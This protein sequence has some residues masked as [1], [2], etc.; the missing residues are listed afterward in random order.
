MH[1]NLAP[2]VTLCLL[3][4]SLSFAEVNLRRVLDDAKVRN[5]LQDKANEKESQS[6]LEKLRDVFKAFDTY[7]RDLSKL[8]KVGAERSYDD[9][10]KKTVAA[11][12]YDP[13]R[14]M[15]FSSSDEFYLASNKF[16]KD[17]RAKFEKERAQV[18]ERLLS[19]PAILKI[20]TRARALG[21]EK[22]L[23]VDAV[24]RDIEGLAKNGNE[25]MFRTIIKD[26]NSLLDMLQQSC[27]TG[28]SNPH[29]PSTNQDRQ[30]DTHQPK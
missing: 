1:R 9:L 17:L 30:T 20:R 29:A 2:L 13:Y 10:V 22:N 3:V 15:K 23:A 4:S 5:V 28:A 12:K 7:A 11:L 27:P 24:L 21:I 26:T 25:R 6:E 18:A 16:L 8:G 19:D 14:E